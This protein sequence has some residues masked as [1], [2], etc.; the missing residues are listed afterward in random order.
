M[1]GFFLCPSVYVYTYED[2][3][4]FFAPGFKHD[5]DDI[6]CA[7]RSIVHLHVHTLGVMQ[8]WR[9]LL[10]KYERGGER[11]PEEVRVS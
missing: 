3:T 7:R 8:S 6:A 1:W 2:S 9:P 11:V 4:L 5:D 10:R